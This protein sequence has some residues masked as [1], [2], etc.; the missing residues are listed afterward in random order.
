MRTGYR[1]VGD[2][3]TRTVVAVS[4]KA[5][6]KEIVTAMDRWKVGALP[7]LDIGGRVVGVVSETD[8][9]VTE[10]QRGARQPPPDG[11]GTVRT[12]VGTTTAGDLMTAP[13]VAIA[14]GAT[15][16]QAARTMARRGVHRL[17][18]LG[19]GRRLVGMVT[20]GDL[21]KVFLRPDEDIAGEVREDVILPLFRA[22]SPPVALADRPRVRVAVEDGVVTLTGDVPDTALIPVAARLAGAVEGVVDVH[23]DL[24]GPVVPG[25][26]AP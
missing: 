5:S 11:R 23:C 9:L 4:R 22:A 13:A 19:A 1:S 2:V 14:E 7:V 26:D 10:E 24:T 21:L 18:V 15:L 3:M 25:W 12:R 17:P 16:P 8:L 20:R 6:F